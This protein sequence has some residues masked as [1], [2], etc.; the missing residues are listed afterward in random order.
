MAY[1]NSGS[2]RN[3]YVEFGTGHPVV[4]LHG[5]G[6]S[7]RAWAA[8]LA[9]LVAAGFR[10][11]VPDHAGHGASSRLREPVGVADLAADVLALLDHLGIE[12]ATL[13]GLSLGG[14]VAMEAALRWPGRVDR[15]VVA[16][17]FAT[18]DTPGFHD[19][20]AAWARLFRSADGPVR[21]FEETWPVNVSPAF[22]S[23]AEALRTWQS[24]HALAALADGASLACV[25]EGIAGFDA[26]G[27]LGELDLPVLFLAGEQ[28]RISPPALS[29]AMAGRV[30]SARLVEIEG[31]AHLSNV[32]S[33]DAFNAALLAFLLEDRQGA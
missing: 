31:A 4:L 30:Q 14:M 18:T 16:N 10:V 3:Y 7:G 15:L 32:D 24:W 6:N 21:R 25:A 17:S 29:Q 22:R 13:A 23:G 2:R 27:R 9:P 8:Q 1:F 26:S 11:I 5:I 12:R 33:A 20:A 19:M 28:D